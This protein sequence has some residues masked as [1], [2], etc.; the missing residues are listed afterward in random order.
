[1]NYLL[2]TNIILHL[3][4]NS[5]LAPVIKEYL[6]ERGSIIA[7]SIVSQGELEAIALRGNYGKR[8]IEEMQKLLSSFVRI[9]IN[10]SEIISCYAE[11]QVFGQGKLDIKPTTQKSAINIPQNDLWIAA[12][13][14]LTKS[15]LL[16][17]DKHFNHFHN[18]YFDVIK[19][20][21]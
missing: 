19:L 12:T 5:T 4:R 21:Y 9:D 2:D 6:S 10:S 1:V 16:T 13:A 18:I 8:K 11:L 7:F 17:C 3:L 15:T 20:N 14:Y